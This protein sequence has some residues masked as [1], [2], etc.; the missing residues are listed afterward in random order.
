MATTEE[1]KMQDALTMIAHVSRVI[2]Q[3]ISNALPVSGDQYLTISVPG[4]V[5]D[6]RD[7]SEGGS[8][9]WLATKT[10]D[11]IIPLAVQQAEA[12]LVDGMMPLATVVVG[13]TGRSVSR[14]YN[15]AL[16]LLVPLKAAGSPGLES[17]PSDPRYTKA[18]EYL[19]SVDATGRTPIDYYILKQTAWQEAQ[20]AWDTA[21]QEAHA[22]FLRPDPLKPEQPT[23]LSAV[24]QAMNEWNQVNFRKYK[25]NVQ[26]K[27]MDWVVQGNKYE[28]ENSFGVVD[29]ESIMAR[30]ESS[31][32]SWRNSTI[33]D[34]DGANELQ[35]VQLT[36]KDWAHLCQVKADDWKDMNGGYSYDQLVAEIGRLREL[37]ISMEAMQEAIASSEFPVGSD[38]DGDKL[39]TSP[40]TEE[41]STDGTPSGDPRPKAEDSVAGPLKSAY[42]ALYAAQGKLT[43][44]YASKA[45]A[46]KIRNQSTTVEGEQ[47]NLFQALGTYRDAVSAQG[48]K[49]LQTFGDNPTGAREWVASQQTQITNSM[50]RLETILLTSDRFKDRNVLPV[51]ADTVKDPQNPDTIS[52]ALASSDDLKEQAVFVPA[53]VEDPKA[54]SIAGSAP[55]DP[56]TSINVSYS[57]TS[58][59]E[60]KTS[61]DWG[62]SV[63]GSVNYGFFSMGGAYSHEEAKADMYRDMSKCDV[64]ISFQAMVVNITR[65]WLYGELFGDYELDVAD[66]VFLSPGPEKLQKWLKDVELN[67]GELKKWTQFPCYP[68]SFVVAA[69]TVIE[70]TGSTTHIEQ[71]FSSHSNSGSMSV[72]YGPFSMS[73]S[74]HE[75]AKSANVQMQATATGCKIMFGSP[76]IIA[77]ASQILPELPR[78]DGFDPLVTKFV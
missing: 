20:S 33:V 56:W 31:K 52:S 46:E 29:I 53:R 64:D 60:T 63:S 74:F 76:Q 78:P 65:P 8:Y 61:S 54:A 6:T 36:P 45:D 30:I 24:N 72:G 50:G 13:N 11:P 55:T 47:K 1:Q 12:R 35:S 69:N 68:T 67:A 3:G 44:L 2:R 43:G 66:K 49:L 75:S 39:D 59:S 22:S 18:L 62:M 15:R 4:T 26:G 7:I 77:W 14:S 41:G 9:V 38:G 23:D 42:A 37:G 70:F 40:N 16:D 32:E 28:V 21:K 71:H 58:F 19:R 57:A 10:H 27:W 73:G 48:K 5:I 34:E 25:T 17:A 51:I